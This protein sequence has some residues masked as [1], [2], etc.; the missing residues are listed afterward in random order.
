MK[1][2]SVAFGAL[3]AVLVAPT[4]AQDDRLVIVIDTFENPA[5]SRSSTIGNALTDMFITSLSRTGAFTVMD[6][7]ARDD[8]DADLYLGAKVTN[9]SYQEERVSDTDTSFFRRSNRETAF[10]QTMN[11][12]IDITAV[13]DSQEILF[14]EAVEHNEIN[15]SA[16][17]ME[18]DYRRLLASSVSVREM[19]GSMMGRATEG[20]IDRAVER[21]TTYF[22]IVGPTAKSVEANIVGL[23]DSRV[24]VIDKGQAAGVRTGDEMTVLRNEP[25]TNASGAVVFTRQTNIGRATVTEVQDAGAL[26]TVGA[27]VG[28]QEGDAVVSALQGLSASDHMR[29][30]AEFF[31]ADFFWAAVREYRDARELDTDA[32]DHYRLGLAHMKSDD[33]DSAFES[34]GRYLDEGETI[35]M[36]ATH[37]HTFGSCSGVFALTRDSA[38]YHSPDESDPDHRF[39]IPFS[40]I[41]RSRH[42]QRGLRQ[43]VEEVELPFLELRAAS[44]KQVRENDG[45]SKNWAFHFDLMEEHD[46]PADIVQMFLTGRGR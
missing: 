29:R 31:D 34:L 33:T 2:S 18:A 36:P 41:D 3:L 35:E 32:V 38:G 11:V 13:D 17:A 4:A 19:T 14:A 15:T 6:G 20:A 12:R 28:V 5:N 40:E 23:V 1:S 37:R 22:E 44:E 9:F 39:F 27:G 10:Q 43:G 45:D 21:L 26:I 46:R 42:V 7:R 30:A 8:I 25:I 16:S 24:A